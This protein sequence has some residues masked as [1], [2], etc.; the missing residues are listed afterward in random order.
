MR[1][2]LLL[3]LYTPRNDSLSILFFVTICRDVFLYRSR[4]TFPLPLHP[5]LTTSNNKQ[6]RKISPLKL[7]TYNTAPCLI[8]SFL[9]F[10]SKPTSIYFFSLSRAE[11]AHFFVAHPRQ[12]MALS[13]RTSTPTSTTTHFR[14]P[15]FHENALGVERS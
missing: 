10:I 9:K 12:S 3:S 1:Y 5:S 4:G 2:T 7:Y 14:G 8:L 13:P 11:H 15:R 6:Q